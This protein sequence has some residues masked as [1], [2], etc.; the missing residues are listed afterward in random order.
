MD[1]PEEPVTYSAPPEIRLHIPETVHA[2]LTAYRILET[3][4]NPLKSQNLL[5]SLQTM[6]D[7]MVPVF[8]TADHGYLQT[9]CTTATRFL[10][11]T[12]LLEQCALSDVQE[13]QLKQEFHTLEEWLLNQLPIIQARLHRIEG[14][15]A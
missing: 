7:V 10:A 5:D 3:L 15:A 12:T 13:T 4:G 2:Y 8:P 1:P 11:L 6:I 9:L 14:K